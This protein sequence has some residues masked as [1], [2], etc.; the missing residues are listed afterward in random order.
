MFSKLEGRDECNFQKAARKNVKKKGYMG[1]RFKDINSKP[2]RNSKGRSGGRRETIREGVC[3]E[4]KTGA[5]QPLSRETK[6]AE[7]GHAGGEV[8]ITEKH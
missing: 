1:M 6:V 2:T 5:L 7:A 4:M 3:R 8:S